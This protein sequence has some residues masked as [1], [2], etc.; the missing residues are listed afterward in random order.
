MTPDMRRTNPN[1][2]NGVPELLVL[3]L[4]AQREMYGYQLVRTIQARSQEAFAFGEGCIYP[5]LHYLEKSKLVTSRRREIDGRTRT[6]YQLTA[7]GK[8]R[9]AE[10]THEWNDVAH[11]V[12]TVLAS[13]PG[14]AS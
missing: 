8:K 12:A 3:R 14:N 1:F 13:E 4:L 9:L 6:Y 10:L 7:R 5:I 2:L 11:G